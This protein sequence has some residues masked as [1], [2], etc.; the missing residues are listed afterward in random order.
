MRR[1]VRWCFPCNNRA[2]GPTVRAEAPMGSPEGCPMNSYDSLCNVPVT[3]SVGSKRWKP[4]TSN[5]PWGKNLLIDLIALQIGAKS[6]KRFG[7][8]SLAAFRPI[9]HR[10]GFR[11][12]SLV[13]VFE[14][15]VERILESISSADSAVASGLALSLGDD[16]EIPSFWFCPLGFAFPRS[17]LWNGTELRSDNE[18]GIFRGPWL[19]MVDNG[20]WLMSVHGICHS[21]LK[22]TN[23]LWMCV[24]SKILLWLIFR[25]N[26]P[27]FW[28][29]SCQIFFR[30]ISSEPGTL[31][32]FGGSWCCVGALFAGES[33][34]H[35]KAKIFRWFRWP[36]TQGIRWHGSKWRSQ[37][38]EH[39]TSW[40]TAFSVGSKS[41]LGVLGWWS[42]LDLWD[43]LTSGKGLSV[44]VFG[45]GCCYA[46]FALFTAKCRSFAKKT[47]YRIGFAKKVTSP[48][49]PSFGSWNT[50]HF[51]PSAVGCLPKDMRCRPFEKVPNAWRSLRPGRWVFWNWQNAQ[52]TKIY[53]MPNANSGFFWRFPKN[54]AKNLPL[55]YLTQDF[56]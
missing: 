19:T 21:V 28:I 44:W 34:R 32:T 9:E 6:P 12:F 4:V 43:T 47:V 5:G 48:T 38:L 10:F 24:F 3:E 8:S 1:R 50:W 36:R 13:C 11:C 2:L 46:K 29:R 49:S 55:T 39:L 7:L 54:S 25:W 33:G 40:L 27:P 56:T 17:L 15:E 35:G 22:N 18:P 37:R 41:R 30:L 52:I 23:S 42:F 53:K 14:T 31:A 26:P 20:W 16:V 51:L 45:F